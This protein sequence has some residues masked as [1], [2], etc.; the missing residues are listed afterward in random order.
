MKLQGILINDAQRQRLAGNKS[1]ILNGSSQLHGHG[2]MPIHPL[3][4]CPVY[5]YSAPA[6]YSFVLWRNMMKVETEFAQN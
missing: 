3:S 4:L 2:R 6:L 1:A 5:G